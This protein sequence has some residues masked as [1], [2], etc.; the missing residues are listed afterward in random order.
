MHHGDIDFAPDTDCPQGPQ[1]LTTTAG[2]EAGV[3]STINPQPSTPPSQRQ[4]AIAEARRL[5]EPAL[6]RRIETD[7]P[8]FRRVIGELGLILA[9][10]ALRD[11]PDEVTDPTQVEFPLDPNQSSESLGP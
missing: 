1:A 11:L 6:L 2:T 7:S 5:I 10:E 4:R 3:P 9:I 8:T